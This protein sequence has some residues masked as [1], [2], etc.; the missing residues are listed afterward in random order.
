MRSTRLVALAVV[1]GCLV[2]EFYGGT[3]YRD[4]ILAEVTVNAILAL[5]FYWCFSLAGQFTFGV[6]AMYAAGAYVSDRTGIANIFLYLGVAGL[7]T[8]LVLLAR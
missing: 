7:I 1:V 4:N 6:F 5:G 2:P 8:K 3:P